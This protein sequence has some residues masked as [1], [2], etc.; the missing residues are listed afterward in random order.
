MIT[1]RRDLNIETGTLSH[2]PNGHH[3][4]SSHLGYHLQTR[5]CMRTCYR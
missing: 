4:S 2:L 3:G 5:Q 1:K